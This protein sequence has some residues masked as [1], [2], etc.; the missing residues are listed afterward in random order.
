[1]PLKS[2]W[3]GSPKYW[4]MTPTILPAKKR[5]TQPLEHNLKFQLSMSRSSN[6]KY[7]VIS[8]T[9][10]AI[11]FCGSPA[12]SRINSSLGER[13]L[14]YLLGG[15][16]TH[17]G[18]HHSLTLWIYNQRV[19]RTAPHLTTQHR[20]YYCDFHRR[21]VLFFLR[22]HRHN[23]ASN[24]RNFQQPLIFFHLPPILARQLILR[25]STVFSRLKK[26][27]FFVSL[28][29]KVFFCLAWKKRCFFLSR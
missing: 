3:M 21:H 13:I 9:R 20:T 18:G 8:S 11:S 7:L 24:S 1:M 22:R 5:M 17:L 27:C 6:W 15:G 4:D 2:H 26:R 16:A 12:R 10:C 23:M 28:E 29:K 14:N 25:I 19:H